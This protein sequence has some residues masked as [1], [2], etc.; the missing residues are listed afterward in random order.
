MTSPWNPTQY[1]RF[2]NERSQPFFD[3]VEMVQ[4]VPGGLAVDLGCGT[5]E[6]TKILHEKVRARET[7]GIDSS[8]TMLAGSAAHAGDGLRFER[9]D[10]TNFA[11]RA[12]LDLLFSN[13]ALQWVNGHETLFPALLA[14]LAEG[15]QVAIQMPANNDHAS[16]RVAFAVAAEEPFASAMGGYQRDWPVGAPEWYAELLDRA[17]FGEQSVRLQV[18]GHHL[19]S[20]DGVVEWVKGTL[21]TDF[22]KRL[23]S[24]LYE[25]FLERYRERLMLELDDSRPFF[26]AFKRVLIWGRK[27]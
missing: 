18:Y 25:R 4:P 9:G 21:L 6:L 23:S 11:P 1:E 16:H 20:R 3:L 14:T 27:G 26:Y 8:E 13:A 12:P 22:E 15:G 17:G 10:V 7:V 5:G 24:E 2:R 19:E